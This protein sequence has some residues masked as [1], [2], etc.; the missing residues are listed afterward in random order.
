MRAGVINAVDLIVGPFTN[1]NMD[2]FILHDKIMVRIRSGEN[3]FLFTFSLSCVH[4]HSFSQKVQSE[5]NI[6]AVL[7]APGKYSVFCLV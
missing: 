4:N 5:S 6:S 7:S 3:F 2:E 1:Q